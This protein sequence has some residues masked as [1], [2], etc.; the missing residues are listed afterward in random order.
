MRFAALF[1]KE[2]KTFIC[3]FSTGIQQ[4]IRKHTAVGLEHIK[5]SFTSY[6]YFSDYMFT[7]NLMTETKQTKWALEIRWITI[8]LLLHLL[9]GCHTWSQNNTFTLRKLHIQVN[10]LQGWFNIDK[11]IYNLREKRLL[12][13]YKKYQT[14]IENTVPLTILLNIV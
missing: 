9:S 3:P 6:I 7:Q 5:F 11:D 2:L 1:L 4:N 12:S 13:I 8:I 14:H 10:T